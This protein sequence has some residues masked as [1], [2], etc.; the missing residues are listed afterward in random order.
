MIHLISNEEAEEQ[1][2]QRG[3]SISSYQQ[4]IRKL[5]ELEINKEQNKNQLLF[6]YCSKCVSNVICIAGHNYT[7]CKSDQFYHQ[8][9]NENI[10]TNEAEEHSRRTFVIHVKVN[11]QK[12]YI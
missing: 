3:Q 6:V 7:H 5:I 2:S 4:Y 9:N 1:L 10:N 12:K 11:H 8:F